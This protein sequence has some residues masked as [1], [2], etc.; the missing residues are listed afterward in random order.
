MSTL[1]WSDNGD[2]L[3]VGLGLS[4]FALNAVYFC[5]P[6][7]TLRDWIF[8]PTVVALCIKLYSLPRDRY[9]PGENFLIGSITAVSTVRA[10]GFCLIL[11]P[12]KDYKRNKDPPGYDITKQSLLEK[13][14][15][16]WGRVLN[17][18]GV[19]W[20]WAVKDLP[21]TDGPAYQ[22]KSAFL[23]MSVKLILFWS[24]IQGFCI[25]YLANFSTFYKYRGSY[26][27]IQSLGDE[28]AVTR[29]FA[30]LAM[31]ISS[32]GEI[33]RIYHVVACLM[34]ILQVSSPHVSYQ[35]AA[36]G[37]SLLTM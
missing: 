30:T 12:E 26:P 37:R 29:A 2:N 25:T 33:T 20:N 32:Y 24:V 6:R 7:N 22:S 17:T 1:A 19:G 9:G 3:P 11:D 18:R 13:W 36:S 16:G 27:G 14:R 28:P 15:W 21:T 8:F 31:R 23:L 10:L 4:L 35:S 5:C 34:V